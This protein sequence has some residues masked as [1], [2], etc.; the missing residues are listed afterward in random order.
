MASLLPRRCQFCGGHAADESICT[1]CA[2]ELPWNYCA[3]P[4]CARPQNHRGTCAD[5]L[6]HPPAFSAA[7]APFQLQPPVQQRVHAIKYRADFGSARL[8][9]RLMAAAA[10]RALPEQAVLMPVPLHRG[11]LWR[12][13]YN[14]SLELGREL[15]RE[16]KLPLQA[17]WARR[18][19]ATADQ[20]GM[21]AAARRRN[22]KNAFE[23]DA[24]VSGRSVILL[25]DVMTTG[26]TLHELARACRRAGAVDVWAWALARVP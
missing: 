17:H 8:L 14:Q 6:A 9:A 20:I 18:L 12:R 15:Q 3:C 5:C 2:A 7:W 25:D 19:R 26:A 11:R 1:A 13:G 21:D 4:R 22:L 23:V 10:P 16:L 24:R